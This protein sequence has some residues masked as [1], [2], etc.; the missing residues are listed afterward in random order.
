MSSILVRWATRWDRKALVEMI[1]A[2]ARQHGEETQ[3]ERL[4]A[5]FDYSLG[6]PERLRYAVAQRDNRVIGTAALHEAYSSWQGAHFGTV[7]DFYV[8]PEERSTGVGTEI[9]ALL[10]DEAKRRG[11]C[12]LEL[13]VQEDNDRAWQ[14]YEARGFHFTG[15]LVYAMEFEEE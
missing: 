12:R 7:E 5:A 3:E 9:L 2:L 6:N 8:L 1:A 15:Y 13:V 4:S 14:F 11:Y 10:V